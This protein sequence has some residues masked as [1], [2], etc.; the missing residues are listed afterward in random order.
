M[1]KIIAISVML[2]LML[3]C[4]G[5]AWAEPKRPPTPVTIVN[6]PANPVPVSG[7]LSGSVSISG[8]PNV[9]VTNTPNVSV[10]NTVPVMN[11]ENPD[12]LPVVLRT[13][14]ANLDV[15][16]N[17]TNAYIEGVVPPGKRWVIEHVSADAQMPAGQVPHSFIIINSDI[18]HTLLLTPQSDTVYNSSYPLKLRVSATRSLGVSFNRGPLTGTTSLYVY[19]SGYEIDCPDCP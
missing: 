18:V 2:N 3:F 14:V 15:G 6:T 8:T 5:T 13:I 11:V 9:S 16:E 7:N 19:F 12:K 4:F 17:S 1:K 10:T